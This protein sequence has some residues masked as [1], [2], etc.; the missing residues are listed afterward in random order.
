MEQP[1]K[2][3]FLLRRSV[4]VAI[5]ASV[6]FQAVRPVFIGERRI[7]HCK[8]KLAQCSVVVRFL[9]LRVG[10]RAVTSFNF[11]G[12]SV[13]QNEI[14][15]GKTGGGAFFLLAVYGYIDWCGFGRA[16]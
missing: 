7:N 14:H 8:V 6:L 16:D 4:A 9:I 5:K 13:M 12:R 3:A 1:S 15:T 10:E 11:G 2:I